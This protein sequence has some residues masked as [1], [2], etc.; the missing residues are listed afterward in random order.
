MSL[1]QQALECTF[2]TKTEL[3]GSPL[4]CS[5]TSGI[6]Y[7]S[8]FPEVEISGAISDSFLF[9]WIGSYKA[10]PEYEPVDMLKADLHALAS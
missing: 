9:R 1:L 8:A 7:C 2:L 6:T 10:N 3:F 5:M 4:K